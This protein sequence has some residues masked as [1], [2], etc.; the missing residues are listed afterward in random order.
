MR[1]E[2]V[3]H[4]YDLFEAACSLVA[5]H[6]KAANTAPL[7]MHRCKDCILDRAGT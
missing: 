1:L 7:F 5:V 4:R 3:K 6:R 2:G